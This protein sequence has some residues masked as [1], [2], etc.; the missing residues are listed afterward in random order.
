MW[1]AAAHFLN[2]QLWTVECGGP[3]VYGLVI[4]LTAY[5]HRMY[6]S[7]IRIFFIYPV[8]ST[9]AEDMYHFKINQSVSLNKS[10][11]TYLCTYICT[12]TYVCAYIHTYIPW[13]HKCVTKTVGCG[14]SHKYTNIQFLQCKIL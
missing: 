9:T 11:I 1:K 3:L 4:G 14:T 7:E 2:K 5:Q 13:I 12:H 6:M 10:E 8:I